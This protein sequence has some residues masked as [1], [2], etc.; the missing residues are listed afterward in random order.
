MTR[1][2]R[3]SRE[4]KNSRRHS[5]GRRNNVQRTEKDDSE[6]EGV[7]SLPQTF[8]SML[9]SGPNRQPDKARKNKARRPTFFRNQFS[10]KHRPPKDSRRPSAEHVRE[11]CKLPGCRNTCFR[12]RGS[13]LYK[14]FCSF[15]HHQMSQ[16]STCLSPGTPTTTSSRSPDINYA[17]RIS[18][19]T[20]KLA[21]TRR[22]LV[23]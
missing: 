19:S 12:S 7:D 11:I 4:G 10:R 22:K 3:S 14:E 13:G 8:L 20:A 2:K 21:E 15:P 1:S 16:V 17:E 18:S 23:V 5:P 6:S 9:A